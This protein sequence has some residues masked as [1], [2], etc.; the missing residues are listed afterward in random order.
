MEQKLFNQGFYKNVENS[1]INAPI[2]P[3][4]ELLIAKRDGK[5]EGKEAD[6][7]ISALKDQDVRRDISRYLYRNSF[8]QQYAISIMGGE[9]NQRFNLSVGY[10]E[11]KSSL[12]GNGYKRLSL[13][14]NHTFKVLK[15]RME[16]TTGVYFTNSKTE[17]NNSGESAIR[18]NNSSVYPYARLARLAETGVIL[19]V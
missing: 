4:V 9:D 1:L 15:D 2:S 18:F 7:Q 14:A 12:V 5:I 10:D 16:L 13:N 19:L 6:G 11:N 3:V 17:N 8:N